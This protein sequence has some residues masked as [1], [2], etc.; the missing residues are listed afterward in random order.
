MYEASVVIGIEYPLHPILVTLLSLYFPR[1]IVFN[2]NFL[3]ACV[4][5]VPWDLW[6]AT[7]PILLLTVK[8]DT[9]L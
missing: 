2:V 5:T 1:A 7:T 3:S 6:F 8:Q 4:N 9:V